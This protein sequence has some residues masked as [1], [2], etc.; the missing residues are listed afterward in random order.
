MGIMAKEIDA[1]AHCC[2][3]VATVATLHQQCLARQVIFELV[4]IGLTTWRSYL[5]HEA[6]LG[7]CPSGTSHASYLLA[8]TRSPY[9]L[10]AGEGEGTANCAP[11]AGDTIAVG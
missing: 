8:D 5:R 9:T 2:T 3:S 10:V 6:G 7:T 1:R 11:A 4:D